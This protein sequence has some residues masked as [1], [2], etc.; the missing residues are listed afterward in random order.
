LDSQNLKSNRTGTRSI[1]L[2]GGIV[3]GVVGGLLLLIVGILLYV[4][5][6]NAQ[7]RRFNNFPP[8]D[9]LGDPPR[10]ETGGL[11]PVRAPRSTMGD[12]LSLYGQ[13]ATSDTGSMHTSTPWQNSGPSEYG[14]RY[15]PPSDVSSSSRRERPWG[16][17]LVQ[18]KDAG[19]T[20]LPPP[21]E[22]V[23][24][25]PPRYDN[26]GAPVRP[27]PEIVAQMRGIRDPI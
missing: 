2:I 11:S 1:A 7:T 13:T 9:I 22:R 4:L 14:S 5:G 27:S 3:G 18:H 21:E 17:D 15:N 10:P 16:S 23:V 6:R 19:V 8:V 25:L 20:L 26:I 24:E 12:I